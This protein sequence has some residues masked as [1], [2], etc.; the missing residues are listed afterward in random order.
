MLNLYMS[1]MRIISNEFNKLLLYNNQYWK[2]KYIN[3]INNKNNNINNNRGITY[4]FDK[5]KHNLMD[6]CLL[7]SFYM[8][9]L[10]KDLLLEGI[11]LIKNLENLYKERREISRGENYKEIKELIDRQEKQLDN[12]KKKLTYNQNNNNTFLGN[13]NSTSNIKNNLGFTYMTNYYNVIN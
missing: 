1:L 8:K 4:N 7:S 2:E 6:L 12:I 10:P 9:G 13:S 5:E 11:N 3:K